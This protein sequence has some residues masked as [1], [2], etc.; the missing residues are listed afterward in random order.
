MLATVMR[1][2]RG[3]DPIWNPLTPRQDEILSWVKGF[4]REHGMPVLSE[5]SN[6]QPSNHLPPLI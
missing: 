1:Q 4:I 5:Y 6:S 3:V 2:V